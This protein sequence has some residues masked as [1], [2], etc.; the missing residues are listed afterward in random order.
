MTELR[1]VNEGAPCV[2][3]TDLK[4]NGNLSALNVCVSLPNEESPPMEKLH[5]L[6]HKGQKTLLY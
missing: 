6:F 3:Y 5:F 2:A 1:P 4:H